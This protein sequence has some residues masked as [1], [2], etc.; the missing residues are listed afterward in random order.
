MN[1]PGQWDWSRITRENTASSWFFVPIGSPH[2]NG[3][4][5]ATV[6]VL[7]KSL[8][9]ALHPGV[10]LSYPE[11]TT[12]LDKISYTVNSRPLGLGNVSQSSQ[13]EDH[14]VPLTPNM[15]L[16]SRSS[17]S[18]PP[19]EYSNDDKFC[20]RLAYVAQV[21]KEWWDRWIKQVLPTLFSYK[22]W[23]IKQK[24]IV[25]GDL[26]MLKYPGQFKDD[27]CMAKVTKADPDEDG[28]V[29]KVTVNFKKRNPRESPTIYKSKPLISE[30]VAVHR[31]HK[32][33]LADEPAL[34]GDHGVV[35]EGGQGEDREDTQSDDVGVGSVQG[36]AELVAKQVISYDNESAPSDVVHDD[37]DPAQSESE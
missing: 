26:V 18:S 2:F 37:G 14:M 13:Q 21:E 19:L 36:D 8:G 1:A 28:L 35:I 23:K 15:M 33:H 27:Y 9:L 22:R 6:G 3:L 30:E 25:A 4:P 10:E 31:L 32:L 7:K 24:N 5:E 11:L 29:R 16:L 20:A 12:L 17:N 34:L